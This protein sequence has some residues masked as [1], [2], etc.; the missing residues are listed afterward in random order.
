[1]YSLVNSEAYK[2]FYTSVL[3]CLNYVAAVFPVT[4]V[5]PKVDQRVTPHKFYN[6]KDQEMFEACKLLC[7]YAHVLASL[8]NFQRRSGDIQGRSDWIAARRAHP[9]RRGGNRHDG[10]R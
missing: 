3:S 9:G 1:M 2:S 4:T 7:Y 5:D 8:T 10:G 6:K